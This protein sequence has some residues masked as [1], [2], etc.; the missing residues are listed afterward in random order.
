VPQICLCIS[1]NCI[2]IEMLVVPFAQG[3]VCAMS[4]SRML[5]GVGDTW[6]GNYEN[7]LACYWIDRM[8]APHPQ[9]MSSP[10]LRAA[11]I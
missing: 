9:V 1:Q 3:M 6:H 2:P 8:D 5:C 11:S 7:D 10:K 4:T